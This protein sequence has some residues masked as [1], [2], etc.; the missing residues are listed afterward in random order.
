MNNY[1]S[2]IT[3]YRS[4]WETRFNLINTSEPEEQKKKIDATSDSEWVRLELLLL[5]VILRVQRITVPLV[6]IMI[7]LLIN[8]SW[9][10]I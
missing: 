7:F 2:N 6:V 5:D 1:S 4:R 9:D 8:N 10:V 3:H